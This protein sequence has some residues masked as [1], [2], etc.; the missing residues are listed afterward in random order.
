M[1]ALRKDRGQASTQPP[2]E[3]TVQFS[4]FINVSIPKASQVLSEEALQLRPTIPAKTVRTYT[5]AHIL[6]TCLT[7]SLQPAESPLAT[8]SAFLSLRKLALGELKDNSHTRKKPVGHINRPPN[9]FILFRCAPSICP[10]N[11]VT[12]AVTDPNLGALNVSRCLAQAAVISSAYPT[13]LPP[14]GAP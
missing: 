11:A 1:P 5:Y 12:N 14:F 13:L 3:N 2:Y 10:P 4:T 6:R 7:H 9:A 8:A